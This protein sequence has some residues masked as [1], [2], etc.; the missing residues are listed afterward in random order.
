MLP[1]E[2]ISLALADGNGKTRS[3]MGLAPDGSAS[4]ILTDRS[5]TSRATMAVDARGVGTVTASDRGAGYAPPEPSD[6]DSTP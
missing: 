3:V 5:G 6:S 1:N 2:A 4:L